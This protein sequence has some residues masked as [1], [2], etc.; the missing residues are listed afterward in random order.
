MAGR[1]EE[2]IAAVEERLSA[3]EG[4]I[5]DTAAERWSHICTAE[6]WPVA[7]VCYHIARGFERQA[8]FIEEAASGIGPHRYSWDETHALNAQIAG[9]HPL[10][11]PDEVLA[12]ARSAIGRVRANVGSMSE[13]DLASVAFINGSFQGSIEWLVRTLMPQHADG[14]LASVQATL[15]A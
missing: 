2:L 1:P 8:S 4:V 10:P 5:R 14:H 15:G 12:T 6:R 13:V 3:L 9:E 7:L 11:A